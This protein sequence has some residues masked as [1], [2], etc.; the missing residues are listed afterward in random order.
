MAQITV[1]VTFVTQDEP[2]GADSGYEGQ[3]VTAEF[4]S[5]YL[6]GAADYLI[7]GATVTAAVAQL[8]TA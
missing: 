1:T 3:E 7:P 6:R 5:E 2:L 8:V 4:V